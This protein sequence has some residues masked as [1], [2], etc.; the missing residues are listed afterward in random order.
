LL[1]FF[2]SQNFTENRTWDQLVTADLIPF[3]RVLSKR[4]QGL[5]E[6]GGVDVFA[7][8]ASQRGRGVNQTDV[9]QLV[10]TSTKASCTGWSDFCALFLLLCFCDRC[11][12]DPYPDLN[13]PFVRIRR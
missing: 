6:G 13:F 5:G 8:L 12:Q 1:F 4:R 7:A 3:L 11:D 2:Y 10:F 9:R